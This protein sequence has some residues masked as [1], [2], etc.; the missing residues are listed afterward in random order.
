MLYSRILWALDKYCHLTVRTIRACQPVEACERRRLSALI[1]EKATEDCIIYGS[2][3]SINEIDTSAHFELDA[4]FVN[5]TGVHKNYKNHK[6]TYN[7]ISGATAHSITDRDEGK[8]YTSRY[9]EIANGRPL[10]T[11]IHDR[12]LYFENDKRVHENVFFID[13][14]LDHHSD[15]KIVPSLHFG[16]YNSQNVIGTALQI[17]FV[18]GYRKVYLSGFDGTIFTDSISGNRIRYGAAPD[19]YENQINSDRIS[20]SQQCIS[21]AKI[22]SLC[23]WLSLIFQ[24]SNRTIINLSSSSVFDMF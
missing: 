10:I 11:L 12:M 16:I 19:G 23:K 3:P 21:W 13:D 5:A 2:G 6:N 17:A 14:G 18:F 8:L 9:L 7:I 15:I 24:N 20:I 22:F 4:F 1:S